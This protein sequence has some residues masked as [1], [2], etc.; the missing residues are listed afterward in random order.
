MFFCRFV[1]GALIER[2]AG[3]SMR[4]LPLKMI[5]PGFDIGAALPKK[6]A[7]L[8]S[9]ILR[10]TDD[11]CNKYCYTNMWMHTVKNKF[12][13]R[14]AAKEPLCVCVCSQNTQFSHTSFLSDKNTQTQ[15]NNTHTHTPEAANPA[16][17][18]CHLVVL[19]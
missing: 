7:L 5:S 2:E 12:I 1:P 4:P 15:T 13:F 6:E 11:R 17:D 18:F 9:P 8:G 14:K 16:P 10:H 19:L 3:N